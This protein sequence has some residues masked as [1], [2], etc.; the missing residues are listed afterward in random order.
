MSLRP[1][2]RSSSLCQDQGELIFCKSLSFLFTKADCSIFAL[3][4]VSCSIRKWILSGNKIPLR[5]KWVAEAGARLAAPRLLRLLVRVEESGEGI[6]FFSVFWY[7]WRILLLEGEGKILYFHGFLVQLLVRLQELGEGKVFP[8][9]FL[10]LLLVKLEE[11][12]KADPKYYLME[13]TNIGLASCC[14]RVEPLQKGLVPFTQLV[15]VR[16]SKLVLALPSI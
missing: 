5:R 7:S 14:R 10:V 11:S 12:L 8:S 6:S 3:S 16:R 9:F 1:T 2:A 4:V 13:F 15:K